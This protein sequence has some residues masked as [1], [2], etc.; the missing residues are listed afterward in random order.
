LE[1]VAAREGWADMTAVQT[2]NVIELDDDV[3]SRWGPRIV[4][5]LQAVSDA[6]SAAS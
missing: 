6:V 3:A 5:F 4:D 1:T 2:S